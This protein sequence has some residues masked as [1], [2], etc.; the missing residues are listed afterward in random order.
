MPTTSSGLIPWI[1]QAAPEAYEQIIR[2]DYQLLAYAQF[3]FLG[4]LLAGTHWSVKIALSREQS[5]GWLDAAI[6][7]LAV[8]MVVSVGHTALRRAMLY[9]LVALTLWS[10][11]RWVTASDWQHALPSASRPWLRPV[12]LALGLLSILTYV[13]MGTI[14]ETARRPYTVRAVIS[15]QDEA[16]YPAADRR[17]TGEGES[18]SANAD[19]KE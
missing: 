5:F 9:L 15:L 16:A 4:L 6:P 2:G 14:R 18:M 13:T 1:R 7:T 17:H 12:A 8:V 10:V 19:G 3:T 11:V